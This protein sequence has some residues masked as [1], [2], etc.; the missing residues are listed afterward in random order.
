MVRGTAYWAGRTVLLTLALI[1]ILLV[2]NV[3]LRLWRDWPVVDSLD[4]VALGFIAIG[5]TAIWLLFLRYVRQL[6]KLRGQVDEGTLAG[7]AYGT[8]G[9]GF[10]SYMMLAEA[11]LMVRR[12]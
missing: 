5:I 10:I 12:H 9:I 6:D 4:R 3:C 11:L 7:L 1:G 8:F 2:A